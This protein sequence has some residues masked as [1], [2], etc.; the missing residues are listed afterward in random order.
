MFFYHIEMM[1]RLNYLV[2]FLDVCLSTR[3]RRRQVIIHI[4]GDEINE[5]TTLQ[6]KHAVILQFEEARDNTTQ[7]PMINR[8]MYTRK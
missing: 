4:L 7:T 6:S 2:V 3:D 1:K 5:R 8:K